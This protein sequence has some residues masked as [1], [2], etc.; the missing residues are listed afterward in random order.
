MASFWI[1]QDN[2]RPHIATNDPMWLE[3]AKHEGFDVNL[4]QQPA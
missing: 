4:I 3:A 1:Q 2:A